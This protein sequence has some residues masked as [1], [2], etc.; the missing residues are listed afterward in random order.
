MPPRAAT[1]RSASSDGN[2][3][4]APVARHSMG[5]TVFDASRNGFP[6]SI[7]TCFSSRWVEGPNPTSARSSSPRASASRATPGIQSG[8]DRRIASSTSSNG[9]GSSR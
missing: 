2:K 4:S 5:R 3:D 7:W 6:S 1:S 9:R 8:G